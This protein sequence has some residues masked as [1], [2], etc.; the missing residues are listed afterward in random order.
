M[1]LVEFESAQMHDQFSIGTGHLYDK[2]ELLA[3]KINYDGLMILTAE[4]GP[5]WMSQM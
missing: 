2:R 1:R 5:K 4:P 3:P